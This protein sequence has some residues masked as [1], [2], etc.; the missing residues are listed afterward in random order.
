MANR[1]L[2]G[3]PGSVGPPLPLVARNTR[4]GYVLEHTKSD[5]VDGH[6]VEAAVSSQRVALSGTEAL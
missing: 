2:V 1:V 3:L 5:R 4:I 6:Y